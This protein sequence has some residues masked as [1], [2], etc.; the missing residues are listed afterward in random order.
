MMTQI[1]EY[2]DFTLIRYKIKRILNFSS[3]MNSSLKF[4]FVF[5]KCLI[6]TIQEVTNIR[7]RLALSLQDDSV[8]I[9]INLHVDDASMVTSKVGFL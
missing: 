4:Y 2:S 9:P 6:R 1:Q 7:Q 3:R 8:K 5:L